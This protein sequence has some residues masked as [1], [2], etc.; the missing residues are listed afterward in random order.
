MNQSHF[1]IP[2]QAYKLGEVIAENINSDRQIILTTHSS[3]LLKGII[4]KSTGVQLIRINRIKDINHAHILNTNEVL[5]I[6]NNPLLASTRVLEGLFYKSTIIVEA[7]ADSIFYKRIADKLENSDNIH[8][9]HAHNK[10]TVSKLIKPYINL[11]VRFSAIIDFDAIRVRSE[12]KNI[13]QNFNV[14]TE[15]ITLILEKQEKIV[16]YIESDE[17]KK[18]LEILKEKLQNEIDKLNTSSDEPD[19]LILNTSRE[20]KRIRESSNAWS[21]YKKNGIVSL[22]Q[23]SKILFND[24]DTICKSYGLFIVPVGE[25]ESWL[26]DDIPYSSNKS[27]WITK[28]LEKI[29]DLDIKDKPIEIFMKEIIEYLN[30]NE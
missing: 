22:D 15:E 23:S 13:L 6:S 20:L 1:F 27:K 11:G 8:F 16:T 5:E 14:S 12:F 17:P 3:D 28:A 25:L 29:S 19:N 4:S 26:I 10:Q 21:D 24:I 7:D 18:R 2:P 30:S 9:V